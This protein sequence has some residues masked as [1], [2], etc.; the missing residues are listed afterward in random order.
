MGPLM[1]NAF[2]CSLE[3]KLERDNKLPNLYRRYVDD[4]ITAMP[5]VAGALSFLYT[6]DECHRSISFTGNEVSE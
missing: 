5:D 2:L 3:E 4:T 1:A 6:H